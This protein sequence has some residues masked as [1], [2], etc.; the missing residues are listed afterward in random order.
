MN[1]SWQGVQAGAPWTPGVTS[2]EG[3]WREWFDIY[4][5]MQSTARRPT[6]NVLI[7]CGYTGSV[8]NPNHSYIA[9][10]AADLLQHRMDQGSAL[11]DDGFYSYQLFG[12]GTDAPYWFDEYSV[13]AVGNAAE[14][15]SKRGYLGAALTTA[16]ELATPATPFLQEDFESGVIPAWLQVPS[17]GVSITHASGETIAGAGSLLIDNP[18]HTTRSNVWAG[19]LPPYH[20]P[21][22]AYTI[23]FDWRIIENLDKRLTAGVYRDDNYT[24]IGSYDVR[25]IMA[26]ESGTS[27]FPVTVPAGLN[28]YLYFQVDNGGK[29]AIDNL[30]IY[31]GGVGPWRRD[32]EN[33]FVLVNPLN[34]SHTF[35]TTELAG[36]ASTAHRRPP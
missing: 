13:D 34:Q 4:R 20:M 26:G 6:V 35:S 16:Q 36:A 14:D 27:R 12:E 1:T 32:F 28:A 17:T 5:T 11:L 22:G 15:Y 10:T 33:G 25:S 29:V 9:P 7:G 24:Q 30:V 31:S 8:I 18:N 2:D 21:S 23:Q 3:Q 19:I